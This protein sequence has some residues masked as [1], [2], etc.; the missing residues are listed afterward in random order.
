MKRS[1]ST[2]SSLSFKYSS[3]EIYFEIVKNPDIFRKNLL[4]SVCGVSIG[5]C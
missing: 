3:I 4:S 1:V 2:N 5:D